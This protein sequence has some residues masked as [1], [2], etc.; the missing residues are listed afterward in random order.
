MLYT[1]RG[2]ALSALGTRSSRSRVDSGHLVSLD[3]SDV[4]LQRLV[5][6]LGGNRRRSGVTFIYASA[7]T[8]TRSGRRSNTSRSLTSTAPRPSTSRWGANDAGRPSPRPACDGD[9]CRGPTIAGAARPVARARIPAQA[10]LRA[11]RDV[12]ADHLVYRAFFVTRYPFGRRTTPNTRRCLRAKGRATS[13][14]NSSASWIQELNDVPRDGQTLGEVVMR[15]NMVMAGYFNDDDA[16]APGRSKADGFIRATWRCVM[17]EASR[18]KFAIERRTSSSAAAR[19][20][21]RSRWR[22]WS[23]FARGGARKRQSSECR[24]RTAVS[25]P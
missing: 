15:G 8:P 10:R 5:L 20:S 7:W 4:P 25:G 14:P 17:Y 24:T 12:R 9:G 23:L 16:T 19:T 6:R 21:R 13:R 22:R 1:H 2:A 3:T 11:D 18:S